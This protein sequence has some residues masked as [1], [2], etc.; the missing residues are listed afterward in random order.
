MLAKPRSRL[1][2]WISGYA[3]LVIGLVTTMLWQRQ[4]VLLEYSTPAA[5]AEWAAWR[6]DVEKEQANPGPVTRRVP[7]SVEP[8]ALVLMRD[9]FGISL[10]G[11]VFFTSILYWIVAWFVSGALQSEY[12]FTD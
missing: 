4:K 11:A 12:H 2:W 6:T 8:P 7:K 10:T 9:Y 1:A 3:V 5:L